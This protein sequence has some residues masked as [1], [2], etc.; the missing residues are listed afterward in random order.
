MRRA[1]DSIDMDRTLDA[2][3]RMITYLLILQEVQH[4]LEQVTLMPPFLLY[5][6]EM[7]PWLRLARQVWGERRFADN[8][9]DVNL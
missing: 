7:T 8:D 1:F 6:E 3:T 9:D 5:P 2:T 4:W